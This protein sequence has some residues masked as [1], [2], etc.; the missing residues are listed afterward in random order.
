MDIL[1]P[2]DYIIVYGEFPAVNGDCIIIAG[3]FSCRSHQKMN[4]ARKGDESATKSLPRNVEQG[5]GS[6]QKSLNR[7][8]IFICGPNT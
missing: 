6:S 8:V 7:S 2:N 3:W 1:T 4:N 5:R